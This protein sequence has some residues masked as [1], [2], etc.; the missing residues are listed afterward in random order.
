MADLSGTQLGE[1]TGR[2]PW[3]LAA[4]DAVA[5]GTNWGNAADRRPHQPAKIGANH[6]GGGVRHLHKSLETFGHERTRKKRPESPQPALFGKRGTLGITCTHGKA[7]SQN[8]SRFGIA[9]FGSSRVPTLRMIKSGLSSTSSAIEEPHRGQKC[10]K[11]DLPLLPRLVYVFIAPSIA[12]ASFGTPIR[13]PNALPV[14]FW[15]SRQ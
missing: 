7:T 5:S 3:R 9:D 15:Q 13:V 2:F 12:T 1:A 4:C 11:I 6:G 8:V 14:N 10:R